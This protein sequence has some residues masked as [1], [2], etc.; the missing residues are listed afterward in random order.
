[1]HTLESYELIPSKITKSSYQ[2]MRNAYKINTQQMDS[3][4]LSL[5]LRLKSRLGNQQTHQ[6]LL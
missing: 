6:E 2:N 1:M 5:V 3:N 4:F